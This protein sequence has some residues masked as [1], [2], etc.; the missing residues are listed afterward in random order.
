MRVNPS[1]LKPSLHVQYT[2]YSTYTTGLVCRS[3]TII[4]KSYTTTGSL[5]TDF[6]TSPYFPY[7][8]GRDSPPSISILTRL[9]SDLGSHACDAAA[10]D[11]TPLPIVTFSHLP[12]TII[13]ALCTLCSSGCNTTWRQPAYTQTKLVTNK[14]DCLPDTTTEPDCLNQPA[15]WQ[16]RLQIRSTLW[17]SRCVSARHQRTMS[18]PFWSTLMV[19]GGV[20]GG[21]RFLNHC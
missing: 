4:R 21:R 6:T 19:N 17:L 5:Q 18:H 7:T 9:Q 1:R 3:K 20:S 10:I 16:T 11:K 12:S 8:G 13:F 14:T 2:S 15:P